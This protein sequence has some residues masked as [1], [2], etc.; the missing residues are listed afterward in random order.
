[1]NTQTMQ[2]TPK[3]G[4]KILI[5]G[6]SN[7][8]SYTFGD[9]DVYTVVSVDPND[10]TLRAKDANGI[11]GDWIRWSDC[12]HFHGLGWEFIQS[13]LPA[14]VTNFLSVFT[15]IESV[16]LR[17]DIKDGILKKLP[18]LHELIMEEHGRLKAATGK[19]EPLPEEDPFR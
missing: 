9:G 19:S 16:E 12:K 3:V 15:G 8:H 14:E 2:K 11:E 18:N 13:V 4:D 10:N 7:N 1:M 5:T 6:N 17:G